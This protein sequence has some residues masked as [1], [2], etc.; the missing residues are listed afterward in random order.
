M[1][2]PGQ[3]VEDDLVVHE[4]ADLRLVGRG[5]PTDQREQGGGAGS[6]VGGRQ[7]AVA[8]QLRSERVGPAMGLE[9]GLGRRR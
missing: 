9:V 1:L 2:G 4:L 7:R 3:E 8:V 6:A 5:Q